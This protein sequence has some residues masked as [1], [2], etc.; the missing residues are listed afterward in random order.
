M[1]RSHNKFCICVPTIQKTGSLDFS[2]I[3][4]KGKV[5]EIWE[6]YEVCYHFTYEIKYFSPLNTSPT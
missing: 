2:F 3:G 5:R 6:T 1:P 4:L